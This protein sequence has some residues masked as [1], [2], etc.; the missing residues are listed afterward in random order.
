[1][2]VSFNFSSMMKVHFDCIVLCSSFEPF[3]FL[4]GCEKMVMNGDQVAVEVKV[5]IS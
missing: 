5:L 3:F 1:M 2:L 4:P